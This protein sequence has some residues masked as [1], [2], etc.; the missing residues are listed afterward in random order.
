MTGLA[1][2]N[3]FDGEALA[4]LPAGPEF[5]RAQRE[6]AH[7]EYEALP[8]PAQ[9][10][11]E[12][13]YTDLSELDL[14]SF[15]AFAPGGQ[16]DNLDD[17]PPEVLLAAGDV[18]ER[19]GLLVQRNS[20]V[21]TAH[22]APELAE[23]GVVFTGLDAAA[24]RLPELVE[25]HLHAI[26]PTDRTK[27][28]ALH[29]AFRTGGTFLYVPPRVRVELPLQS[30]T[31]LD[32]GSAAVFPHTL[33]VV[34]EQADVTFIDR[35][36]SPALDR[37]LSDAVVE[38]DVGPASKVSY[39][40]LQ[41]WGEGVTHVSVQR[42]RLARDAEFHSLS[43]AF[44]ADLS[45]NEFES[46]LAEPGGHSEMLGLYF[47]DGSQH[48]DHRT[49]QDHEAPNGTS[50]LLYKGALKGASRAIYSGWVH[51]RPGA[52]RSD[53]FQTNRNIVLSE[54]AK[55]DA[56]PNLE[57]ENNEVRCGHAASV[58]PVDEE[59]LFYLQSRGIPRKE[60]ERLIVFGFFREVLDRVGLEEVRRGLEQAI[61]R[62]L[63]R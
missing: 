53:A 22:L 18:G 35:Y 58:G 52:S 46:V 13:R 41:E 56:I 11:E 1:T 36:V 54:H 47:A 24:E 38:I 31:Y 4:A 29:G 9:E 20:E 34:G 12:W 10:T 6:R 25:P 21:L 37:A 42:A 32:A 49:L 5:I 17:V 62:E 33:I 8:V 15:R 48:F 27:F 50:Q 55:A 59:A 7:A 39:V 40:S 57:I 51:I 19:A 3:G 44:G 14:G 60:A 43:V 26:V 16:A 63:E 30:L 61:E 2:R 23:Q 28:T 45:R